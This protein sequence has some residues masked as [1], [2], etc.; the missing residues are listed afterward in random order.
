MQPTAPSTDDEHASR[1]LLRLGRAHTRAPVRHSFSR[2]YP[3]RSWRKGTRTCARVMLDE[4]GSLPVTAAHAA[5]PALRDA[6]SNQML[7]HVLVV[8]PL[9]ASDPCVCKPCR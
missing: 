3:S 4:P 2:M 1:N 6:L 5:R 9:I 8:V 7:G